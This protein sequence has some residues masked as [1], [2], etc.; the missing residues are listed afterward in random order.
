MESGFCLACR[1]NGTVPDLTV[2]GNLERW[3][4]LEAAKHRLFYS[5]LRWHLPLRTRGEDLQHGLIFNF[6]ANTPAAKAMTGHENGIITI[7]LAEADDIERERRGSGWASLTAPFSVTSATRSGIISGTC[8]FM[9][10]GG[11]RKLAERYSVTTMRI[12]RRRCNGT[13]KRVRHRPGSSATCRPMLQSILR[14]ASPKLG[15]TTCISSI[16]LRWLA[17]SELK[18]GL[19]RTCPAAC[20]ARI[21]FDPYVVDDFQRTLDAW[22]PFVFA[23]NS[24]NRAIGL[25]RHV[26]FQSLPRP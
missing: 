14:R 19:P 25:H 2:P 10:E 16:L 4:E 8:S 6:L 9:T 11:L 17:T 18:C 21:D 22:L 3:H 7:A 13:T 20:P 24:V 23:M 1:H 12:T 26:S 15:R 5:L